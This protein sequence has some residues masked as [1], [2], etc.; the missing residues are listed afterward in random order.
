MSASFLGE[1]PLP[2]FLDRLRERQ[3]T[4]AI[5]SQAPEWRQWLQYW[6]DEESVAGNLRNFEHW[7]LRAQPRS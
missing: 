7:L 4:D 5:T 3:L 2:N 1:T 6:D